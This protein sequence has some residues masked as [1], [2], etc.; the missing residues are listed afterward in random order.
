[1]KMKGR[2]HM[3]KTGRRRREEEKKKTSFREFWDAY[4]HH[5]L[6]TLE[7]ASRKIPPGSYIGTK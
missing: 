4:G 3:A 7:K 6:V 5:D 1:M 2:R